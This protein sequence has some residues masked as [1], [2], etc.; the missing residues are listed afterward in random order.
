LVAE[1]A[2]DK[3][4]KRLKY[5]VLTAALSVEQSAMTKMAK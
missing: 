2:K 1:F 4:E 3:N 5:R